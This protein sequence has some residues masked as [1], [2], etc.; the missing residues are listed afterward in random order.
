MSL[1]GQTLIRNIER[2]W[3]ER[4][5]KNNLDLIILRLLRTRPQWGYEVN[6]AIRDKYRVYLSAGTLYP[7]LHSLES[8]GYIQGEWEAEKGRGRRIYKI[9]EAGINFLEAGERATLEL[10]RLIQ[11]QSQTSQPKP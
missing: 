8:D 2:D 6:I 11:G 10:A 3:R 9:T 7:L 4:V 1:Q 5:V